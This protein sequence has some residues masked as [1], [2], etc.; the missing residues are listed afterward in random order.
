[1]NGTARKWLTIPFGDM[2]CAQHSDFSDETP[3]PDSDFGDTALALHSFENIVAQALVASGHEL[4]FSCKDQ[5]SSENTMEIDFLIRNGIK[6][7]PIEVKSG[8]YRAHISLDR[9][10][11][12]HSRNIGRCYVV[13]TGDYHEDVDIFI[14]FFFEFF[15][16]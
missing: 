13:C 15:V 16:F 5:Q 9:F 11:Q 6:V 12:R 10:S 14:H 2:P 7:C 3:F 1:M 4:F 8:N